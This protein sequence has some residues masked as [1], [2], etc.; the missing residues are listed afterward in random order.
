M[1]CK[2]CYI[3]REYLQY[4]DTVSTSKVERTTYIVL[5]VREVTRS[6]E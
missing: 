6:G 1:L 4:S 2:I 3:L 5:T